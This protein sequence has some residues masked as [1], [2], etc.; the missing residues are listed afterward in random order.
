MTRLLV[1]RLVREGTVGNDRIMY[2]QLHHTGSSLVQ[3]LSSNQS[4]GLLYLSF[5]GGSQRY[6]HLRASPAT[7]I[8]GLS[9]H[10]ASW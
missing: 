6:K 2:M 3:H 10:A 1:L 9:S 4:T 8:E 7:G 5:S